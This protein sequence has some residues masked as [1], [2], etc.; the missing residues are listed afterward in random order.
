MKILLI[1]SLWITGTSCYYPR[2]IFDNYV[3]ESEPVYFQL[4]KAY[5]GNPGIQ[6]RHIIQA[7]LKGFLGFLGTI[8]FGKIFELCQGE[9]YNYDPKAVSIYNAYASTTSLTINII[10]NFGLTA[11]LIIL[12]WTLALLFPPLCIKDHELV[13]DNIGAINPWTDC[14]L[15]RLGNDKYEDFS[16]IDTDITDDPG[17][18]KY[19]II[20]T[21]LNQIFLPFS[22]V[23]ELVATVMGLSSKF[24]FWAIVPGVLS[25]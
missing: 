23:R 5:F 17:Y 24:L 2:S 21:A 22:I 4:L 7:P 20:I 13:I 6:V 18:N 1:I 11:A 19:D 25:I 10:K 12:W 9:D 3:F 8:F 14:G 16:D 15:S